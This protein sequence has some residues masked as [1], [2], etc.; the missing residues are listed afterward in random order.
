MKKKTPSPSLG[1]PLLSFGSP[2]SAR[3]ASATDVTMLSTVTTSGGRRRQVQQP[4]STNSLLLEGAG[5][6]RK[7]HKGKLLQN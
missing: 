2:T 3:P 6:T 4:P 1:V 7:E 5:G